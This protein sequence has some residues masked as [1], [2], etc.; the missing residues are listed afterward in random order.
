MFLF[1]S[2]SLKPSVQ[3]NAESASQFTCAECEAPPV[4]VWLPATELSGG[5]CCDSPGKG[6]PAAWAWFPLDLTPCAFC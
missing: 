3:F 4:H 2:Q 1:Y 5:R 6:P